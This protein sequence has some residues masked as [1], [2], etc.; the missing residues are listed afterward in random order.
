MGMMSHELR[1]P[2]NVFVGYTEMMLDA[3][4]ES[5]GGSMGEHREVLERM[6]DAAGIL[7]N[8]VEDTLSVLRLEG[9]GVRV[10]LEEL[11]LQSLFSELQAASRFQR[12][13][14]E[15][16][17]R[18]VVEHELPPIVCDRMKLRQI[19]TNLVSNARKFTAAGFIEVNAKRIDDG[20]AIT[21][22]DT[23]CGIAPADLPFVFD[24]YRQAGN[25]GSQ[26]NG[27]GIGLYIVRRYCQVLGGRVELDSDLGKGT[28]ITIALPAVDG[29]GSKPEPLLVCG[30]ARKLGRKRNSFRGKAA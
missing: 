22:E 21:V 11:S 13:P 23:G 9:A 5:H 29:A 30:T 12:A 16:V 14:S 28:R 2:L 18:W 1:T 3:A 20:V 25:G 17:E 4:R 24:L 19:L 7:T 8:L 10:S 26:H 6:L 27:C 15:V